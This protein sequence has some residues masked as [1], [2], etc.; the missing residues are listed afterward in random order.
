MTLKGKHALV[1]GGSRGIGRGIVLK[2]AEQGARVAVHYYRN[3]AAAKETLERAKKHGAD[4]VL[5]QADVCRPDE[6][7]RMFG[8][9]KRHFGTLDVFVAN[10]RPDP[11]DFYQKPMDISLEQWDKAVDSQAKAF[12]V[13]VREAVPM[14]GAGGRI[15]AITYAPAARTGTWQPFFA[16]GAGKAALEAC[17]RYFAVALAKRGITVN[18]LSPGLTDDS[19][20]NG[21]PAAV[22]ETARKWH[23]SGWTPMGRMGT[24]ADVGNAVALFCA[25]G[26][27]WITG[28]VIYVDGGASLAD[29]LLPLELQLG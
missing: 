3:E 15:L 11:P 10:A 20:L 19:V 24:P 4:G 8:D 17:V 1:T 18:A 14:M 16:M 25:E 26:A 6:V 29:T 5:V 9:V 23:Q 7:K 28:Q 2:L 21:F 13:G 27:G 12:L 22:V